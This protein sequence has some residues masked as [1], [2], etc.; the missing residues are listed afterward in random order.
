VS[1]CRHGGYAKSPVS[2]LCYK[3]KIEKLEAQLKAACDKVLLANEAAQAANT[4][5]LDAEKQLEAQLSETRI[6][7]QKDLDFWHKQTELREKGLKKAEAQLEAAH[8]LIHQIEDEIK[9]TG[10]EIHVRKSINN[11]RAALQESE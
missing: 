3:C 5:R 4:L 7:H 8:T 10:S 6:K 9:F 11:Y 1:K 2:G